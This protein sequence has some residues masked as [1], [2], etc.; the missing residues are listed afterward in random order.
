MVL[1]AGFHGFLENPNSQFGEPQSYWT[2][3][4][5]KTEI[6]SAYRMLNDCMQSL[7]VCVLNDATL[8]VVAFC[9]YC[10]TGAAHALYGTL[11]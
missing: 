2:E 6:I 11:Q 5:Y 9:S 4:I 1:L 10:S 3:A 7:I 8:I